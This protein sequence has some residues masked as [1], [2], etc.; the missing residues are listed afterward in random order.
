MFGGDELAKAAMAGAV[1]L[2]HAALNNSADRCRASRLKADAE[3]INGGGFQETLP[4]TLQGRA[5]FFL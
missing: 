5:R 1:D 3:W 4:V 2:P